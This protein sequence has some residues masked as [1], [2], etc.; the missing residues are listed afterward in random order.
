MKMYIIQWVVEFL[1]QPLQKKEI[2]VIIIA[3]MKVSEQCAMAASSENQMLGLI[4]RH[5]TNNPIVLN[6]SEASLTIMYTSVEA[7]SQNAIYMLE[8]V[9]RR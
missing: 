5:K 1:V 8:R 6:N 7:L 4:R 9:Q 2:R 3:D